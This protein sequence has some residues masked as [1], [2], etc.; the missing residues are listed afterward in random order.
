VKVVVATGGLRS[1]HR[2][3]QGQPWRAGFRAGRPWCTRQPLVGRLR[4]RRSRFHKHERG[5]TSLLSCPRRRPARTSQRLLRSPFRLWSLWRKGERD[6]TSRT[7]LRHWRPSS[8]RRRP[9]RH[10]AARLRL[11]R[12]RWQVAPW[13]M[14]CLRRPC[15][16]TPRAR[17]RDQLALARFVAARPVVV[18]EQ[19]GAFERRLEPYPM[20]RSSA[21]RRRWPRGRSERRRSPQEVLAT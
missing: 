19:A 4:G 1:P 11:S 9:D 13:R 16:A 3:G 17:V 5:R 18:V 21:C 6:G 14:R 15:G 10:F 12:R 20:R 2:D 7:S 8:T